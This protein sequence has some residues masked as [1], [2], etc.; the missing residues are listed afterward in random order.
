MNLNFLRIIL[1]IPLITCGGII[2]FYY[3]SNTSYDKLVIAPVYIFITCLVYIG[4]QVLKR[5][6]IKER[7]WW[8]WLYYIGLIS[9]TLPVLIGTIENLPLMHNIATIGSLFFILPA[10][11][12]GL[13]LI[14]KQV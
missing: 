13:K 14:K 3:W 12:D 5:S 11:L 8:D 9:V 7:N 1:L 6:L 2:F 4:L 10:G